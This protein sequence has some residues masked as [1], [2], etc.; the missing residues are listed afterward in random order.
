[1]AKAY[2]AYHYGGNSSEVE[3]RSRAL[4]HCMTSGCLVAMELLCSIIE[5]TTVSV[6]RLPSELPA[7]GKQWKTF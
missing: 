4:G 2:F 7:N 5:P 6:T 3:V 1:M